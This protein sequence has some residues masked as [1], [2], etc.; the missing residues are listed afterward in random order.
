MPVKGFESNDVGCVT[1]DDKDE[2]DRIIAAL[3]AEN[4]R[5]VKIGYKKVYF[6]DACVKR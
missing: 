6:M 2:R 5:V 4:I 1:A 3:K